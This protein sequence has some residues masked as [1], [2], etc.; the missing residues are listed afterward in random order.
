MFS[1][2]SLYYIS[3]H[4]AATTVEMFKATVLLMPQEQ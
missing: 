1:K 4:A 3:S 2:L